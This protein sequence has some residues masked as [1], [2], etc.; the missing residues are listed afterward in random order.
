[1]TN[2]PATNANQLAEAAS[3]I[4]LLSPDQFQLLLQVFIFILFIFVVGA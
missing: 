2:H 3:K 1:M 4:S